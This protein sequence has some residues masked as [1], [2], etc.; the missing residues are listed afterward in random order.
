M[1]LADAIGTEQATTDEGDPPQPPPYER[2]HHAP[3]T[4]PRPAPRAGFERRPVAFPNMAPAA[5]ALTAP[6]PAPRG[7]V[8]P[9][10][11]PP[12]TARPTTVPIA[13]AVGPARLL[14]EFGAA[15]G[16]STAVSLDEHRRRYPAPPPPRGA[17]RAELIAFI[18]RAGLCGRGGAAFPTARKLHAVAAGPGPAVVIVN[19]AEG[20]PGSGKDSL[21]LRRLPHLVL[22]GALTAAAA[23]GA[24]RVVVCVDRTNTSALAAVTQAVAERAAAPGTEGGVAID[25]AAIPPRYVAGESSALVQWL[26]NGPAKPT[27]SPP[28]PYQRGVGGR[29]TLVQNVETLAHLAQVA[30][31]GPDWFRQVGTTAEPGTVL[32]SVSGA[33]ARPSVVET[34]IGTPIDLILEAAG[35]VVRQP[36]ALLIGG[37]FGTWVSFDDA[38]QAPYSRAGLAPFGAQPGAGV[39]IALP[40]DACG[41][42]ETARIMSW[43]AAES[44][45]QCGPCLYGLADLAAGAASLVQPQ[46]TAGHAM[47]P[48][49]DPG[50]GL[51]QGPG[52][53]AQLRRW[54]DQIEGRGACHHPDGAVNLL[55]SALRVFADDLARH[56][57]GWPCAG[58]SAPPALH[59]PPAN[60][61]WR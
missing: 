45:G 23:V 14:A 11:R 1:R 31:F 43:Y 60:T 46:A 42:A 15:A 32:L 29:A 57:Q 21:L 16:S 52:Q 22:D 35:G 38:R 56:E 55:R 24:N 41:L 40:G 13:R 2:P 59:V 8:P 30:A 48:G 17:G 44:A 10:I 54:A 3:W 36:Q 49:T 7:T 26:N 18:E 27:S 19:G 34:A 37:F 33:V 53:V 9:T 25:L 47:N 51:N 20:E 50:P 28:R 5:A 39:I 6:A 4:P 58:A 12:A 61:I